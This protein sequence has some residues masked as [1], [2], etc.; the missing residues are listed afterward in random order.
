MGKIFDRIIKLSACDLLEVPVVVTLDSI[1]IGPA[2]TTSCERTDVNLLGFLY[3]DL[4]LINVSEA[5]LHARI[6]FCT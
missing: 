3:H 5:L 4:P 2:G 6:S 1:Q